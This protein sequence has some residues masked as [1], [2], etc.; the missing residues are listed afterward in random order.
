MKNYIVIM[1]FYPL[2]LFTS[3]VVLSME[4]VSSQE[5]VSSVIPNWQL[6][7]EKAAERAKAGYQ[8]GKRLLLAVPPKIS[9]GVQ[10]VRQ[11]ERAPRATASQWYRFDPRRLFYRELTQQEQAEKELQDSF[12]QEFSE[13]YWKYIY[14][15]HKIL[16][17]FK[18]TIDRYRY[19]LNIISQDYK[20]ALEI[21]KQI[22]EYLLNLDRKEHELN[23]KKNELESTQKSLERV[24][25]KGQRSSMLDRLNQL[26]NQIQQHAAKTNK[27]RNDLEAQD[28]E[29]LRLKE[30]QDQLS[31][32][33]IKLEQ[34]EQEF[35]KVLENLK[36]QV[37]RLQQSFEEG[38]IDAQ[39]KIEQ[40]KKIYQDYKNIKQQITIPVSKEKPLSQTQTQQS[41]IQKQQI[42]EEAK[43]YLFPTPSAPSSLSNED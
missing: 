32:F 35:E 9:E 19:E 17:G 3:N 20:K 38:F 28:M 22:T 37:K 43:P 10:S 13:E 7:K 36:D 42:P 15:Q 5:K 4:E 30:T 39:E 31:R 26:D 33:I 12:K 1:I 27:V 6:I 34:E 40:G 11:F 29:V 25:Q 41:Q 14:D 16:E 8:T 24:Q 18:K 21:Q 2:C 23:R